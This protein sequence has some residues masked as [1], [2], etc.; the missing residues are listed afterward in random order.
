MIDLTDVSLYYGSQKIIKAYLGEQLLYEIDIGNGTKWITA[1]ESDFEED[2]NGRFLSINYVGIDQ[3]VYIPDTIFDGYGDH[4]DKTFMNNNNILG[5]KNDVGH[6]VGM[7]EM[8]RGCTLDSL[9]ITELHTNNVQSMNGMFWDANITD[10]DFRNFD[11]SS[12]GVFM[13]MFHGATIPFLD[14]S[15]FDTTKGTNFAAMFF[16]ANIDYL[17]LSSFMISPRS[18]MQSMF[19]RAKIDYLDIS[20]IVLTDTQSSLWMFEGAKIRTLVV[21]SQEQLNLFIE[22]G[23]L[24]TQGMEIIIRN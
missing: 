10:I 21:H 12:V 5:V 19:R 23:Y 6:A 16:N 11:T 9:D 2:F 1:T 14:L 8:F 17:N 3:Y 13:H 22:H 15:S 20:S 7:R 18:A 4:Y 24:N